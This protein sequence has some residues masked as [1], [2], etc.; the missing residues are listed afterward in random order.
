MVMYREQN[1]GRS[2]KI[3]TDVSPFWKGGIGQKLG[4]KLNELKI[5]FRKK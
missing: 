1:A 3:K 2:H 5:L 4:N